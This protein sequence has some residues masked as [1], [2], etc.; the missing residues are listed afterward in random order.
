MRKFLVLSRLNL[1]LAAK[2]QNDMYRTQETRDADFYHVKVIL[3]NKYYESNSSGRR[4]NLV[5]RYLIEF[6]YFLYNLRFHSSASKKRIL[7]YFLVKI[8][9]KFTGTISVRFY[10]LKFQ[11]CFRS[12][13][14]FCHFNL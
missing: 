12:I 3:F 2:I 4:L 1:Q 9:A 11:T 10:I 5:T 14:H 6:L 8:V 13:D 7:L